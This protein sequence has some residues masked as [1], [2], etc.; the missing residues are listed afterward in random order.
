MDIP[1]AMM[2]APLAIFGLLLRDGS[3]AKQ[4]IAAGAIDPEHARKPRSIGVT[5]DREVTDAMRRGELVSMGDGRYWVHLG[6]H[7]RR[8]LI[9]WGFVLGV[10]TTAAVV[11]LVVWLRTHL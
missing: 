5:S 8:R 2:M 4:F 11:M 10:W 3:P 9:M 1:P 7:R 6:R